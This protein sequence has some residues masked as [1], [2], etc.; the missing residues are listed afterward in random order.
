MFKK[1]AAPAAG[2]YTISKSLR[3]RSSASAYLNRT[4]GSSGSTQKLTWSGWVK[5]STSSTYSV[6]FSA[7]NTAGTDQDAMYID[8]S[9]GM[10]IIFNGNTGGTLLTSQV[11]RDPGSWY[12]I[13]LAIDTTQATASN[14]VKFYVNGVQTTAFST[15]TYP[16]QNYN[17]QGWNVSGRQAPTA[18][19]RTWYWPTVPWPCQ[20]PR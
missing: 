15:A 7:Q 13:V 17:F 1:S 2:G 16:A 6:L 8:V 20:L 18:C 3:F 10:S 19:R 9:Q 12:H 5:Y 4:P 11:F 14:R